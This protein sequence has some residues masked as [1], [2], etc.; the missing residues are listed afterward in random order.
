MSEQSMGPSAQQA[1]D[2][3]LIP[4]R[5]FNGADVVSPA[6]PMFAEVEAIAFETRTGKVAYA[7]RSVGGLP[8]MGDD[9]QPHRRAA[10]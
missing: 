4:A 6:K 10:G 2:H 9:R 3:P 7:I 1:I 8:A 5:R